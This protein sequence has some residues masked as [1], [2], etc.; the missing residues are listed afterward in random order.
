MKK[1]IYLSLIICLFGVNLV[2]AQEEKEEEKSRPK[3]MKLIYSSNWDWDWHCSCRRD[4]EK[5]PEKKPNKES[6]SY[7]YYY[8]DNGIDNEFDFF[9][10]IGP[11]PAVYGFA[12][13]A[14]AIHFNRVNG[15][16]LGIDTDYND[17]SHDLTRI[18]G[19][20]IQALGGYSFGREEWQYQIGIEKPIGRSFRLGFNYHNITATDDQWRSGLLENSLSSLFFGYDYHDYYKSVGYNV[21]SS[22]KLFRSTY[23]GFSYGAD[24]Y[25]SLD[26]VTEYN[27]FGDG[28]MYRLNPAID[29]N[30][31][32]I[33]HQNLGFSVNINPR[34]YNIT[35]NISTSLEI[36]GEIG[37]LP[38]SSNDFLFNKYIAQTKTIF[39]LDNSTFLKWRLMG[40]A[41]TGQAP[42]FKQFALGGVGTMRATNYKSMQGNTML[43]SNLELI[44][45]RAQN[46]DF[47]FLDIDGFYFTLFMDS[48]WSEFDANLN[49]AVSPVN[50][51][52][53]FSISDLTHNAGIGIGN[54]LLRVE[55]AKPLNESGGFSAFWVRLNPTF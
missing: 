1:H 50:G 10:Q 18:E 26:L 33:Y 47:G 54:D 2:Q 52:K 12:P 46:I 41:I 34:L 31:D 45:G 30:F 55:F 49:T 25:N 19:F 27:I 32:Q 7:R 39:R 23:I 15:F 6:K 44:F 28:N 43:L 14:Q 13:V 9:S 51:F 38:T 48:G 4:A 20:E 8:S 24:T 37:N 29:S 5:K 22:L 40:G 16:F 36:R 53:E 21:Y 3:D 42:D 11:N 35:N 17:F